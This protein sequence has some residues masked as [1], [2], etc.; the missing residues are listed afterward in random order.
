MR[1]DGEQADD[2]DLAAYHRVVQSAREVDLP[3]AAPKSYDVVAR[4]VRIPHPALGRAGRWV[5]RRSGEVIAVAHAFFPDGGNAHIALAE[6]TVHP[7][8]RRQGIG[9]AFLQAVL[10]ELRARG[11]RVVEGQTAAFGAGEKWAHA[12]GA[13][14]VNATVVQELRV[15]EVDPSL[16]EVGVPEG[17]RLEAW[18]GA[19]PDDLVASYVNAKTAMYDAPRGTA[20]FG[21]PEWTVER[22][23]GIEAELRRNNREQRVVAAVHEATGEVAG[24]TELWLPLPPGRE[25]IQ[26]D[27]AVLA[28]HRGHGLGVRVKARALRDLKA[29]GIELD[30]ITTGT[31]ADNEHMI[32]VNLALG[33]ATVRSMVEVNRTVEA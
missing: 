26:L 29:D 33:Y 4:S 24:F 22:V 14:T 5:A 30:L 18:S 3:G 23:R 21:H 19:A 1:F 17:Y 8:A 6:I 12:L 9:T 7:E 2:A 15:A 11:R 10:P 16:W 25:G 32:R 27:T 28:A 31:N 20:D 13:R